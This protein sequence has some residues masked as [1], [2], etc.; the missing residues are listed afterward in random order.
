MKEAMETEKLHALRTRVER[1]RKDAETVITRKESRDELSV[2]MLKG[3][4][5]VQTDVERRMRERIAQETLKSSAK[6]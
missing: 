3:K 5:T 6:W 1:S 2:N 4:N